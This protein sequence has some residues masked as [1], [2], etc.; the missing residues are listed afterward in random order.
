[1][2]STAGKLI[3][4]ALIGAA[5]CVQ[6]DTTVLVDSTQDWAGYMHVYQ[7][8]GTTLV[9]EES[10]Y[11]PDLKA[12]FAD[13]ELILQACPIN[14]PATPNWYVSAG[15]PGIAGTKSMEATYYVEKG[16]ELSGQN[17]TF[18]G[19]VL[20]NTLVSP[21]HSVAF[22]K[23]FA[24][25]YS[26]ANTATVPL[27]NGAFTVSLA[28]LPGAGRHVQYGFKT[29]GPNVWPTDVGSKG[30]VRIL[31]IPSAVTPTIPNGNFEISGGTGWGTT[32]GTP[33]YPTTGGNPTGHTVLNGSGNFT[34]LYAYIN[35]E[36]T[37]TS[38]GL[39][40]GD[41]YTLQVDM[42]L[43]S[44]GNM[45]G[46]RL[47]GPLGYVD[48]RFATAN[49][50]GTGWATYSF[51]LTV[52]TSPVQAK[53]G[54]R[55]GNDSIVAFDNIKILVPGPLRATIT[56]GT[57]VSWTAPSAVNRYQPEKAK[58]LSGPWTIVGTPIIGNTVTSAFDTSKSNHYRVQESDLIS[59][60]V[61][62]NGNFSLADGFV[63]DGWAL[64]QSQGPTYRATGGRSDNGPCMR[65][66]VQN[67]GSETNGSEL[68]QKVNVLQSQNGEVVPGSTYTLSFWTKQI[69]SGPS[70][71]QEYR[72]Y[73]LGWGSDAENG[74]WHRFTSTVGGGWEQQIV[75]GLV[76]SEWSPEALIQIV[77]KTGA[78]SGDSGE[79]L[80]DDV[81]L[82][83]TRYLPS[84][85]LPATAVPS[86]E[87]SW[88]AASGKNYQVQSSVNLATW[89]NFGGVVAGNNTIKAVYDP[90]VLPKK[91]YKVGKLP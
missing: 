79:V 56:Q 9:S 72:V 73:F 7:P 52:P 25:D 26:S 82:A 29:F 4:S 63:A 2:N 85:V 5:S 80:I 15:G 39:A 75:S 14:N 48:E 23:D 3:L 71:E 78:V 44:G 68:Q 41:T 31:N 74:T 61:A 35:T 28:T 91:F 30:A 62:Y 57:S 46:V 34:V 83:A 37:F 32:Q 51:Q 11:A 88:P 43:V 89:S 76:A 81:S 77:G 87:I 18:S 12:G 50:G 65:I 16:S 47:E 58:T 13:G 69:S 38:L 90:K 59:Q 60:E 54:L 8:D 55:P 84:S 33:T 67:V 21:H 86:V 45:G 40:P 22:I 70:Y 53:I 27:V 20:N 36:K 1:M 49:L 66:K 19:T 6:A 17:V 10:W 24:L 64:L 42:K